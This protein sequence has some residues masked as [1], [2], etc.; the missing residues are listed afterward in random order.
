MTQRELEKRA[1]VSVDRVLSGADKDL[2]RE[3]Q[4]AL[5]SVK[6]E[7]SDIYEKY[8]SG[9]TLTYSEMSKYN[10]LKT[11]N[12]NIAAE[13]NALGQA[14]DA[15][16]KTLVGDAYQESYYRHGFAMDMGNDLDIGFGPVRRETL[17]SLIN[18]PNVSGLAL[19]EQLSKQRYDLLLRQRQTMVQG[20]VKGE[21]YVNIAK[22]LTESFGISLNNAMRIARTEGARAATEGHVSAYNEAEARGVEMDRIWVASLD[23][24]TRPTHGALDGQVADEDGMFHSEGMTAEGPGL[25]G[26]PAYDIRCRCTIRSEIKG[27]PPELRRYD[28]EVRENITYAEW[29]ALHE[30]D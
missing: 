13:L 24:R 7:L 6:S 20:F 15:T 25:W 11:L 16:I 3:Y 14:Q 17:T 22:S 12:K 30:K 26:D 28:G 19:K 29:K 27:F 2:V 21:S 8:S 9:G 23:G 10:R 4:K 18:E 1:E 5:K